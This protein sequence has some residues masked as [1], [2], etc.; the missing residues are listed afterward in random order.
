MSSST[1]DVNQEFISRIGDYGLKP[2]WDRYMTLMSLQPRVVSVPHRWR[3]Q[4]IKEFL[5]E[6]ADLVTAED[7]ERR[8]LLLENPALPGTC[9]VTETLLTGVQIISPGESAPLHRHVPSDARLILEGVE[10]A[11]TTVNGTK[12]E[13]HYADFIITPNWTWHD[14][15]HNGDTPVVWQD[16]LDIP[17][18]NSV[19]PVFFENAPQEEQIEE[20]LQDKQMPAHDATHENEK[21]GTDMFSP[22][23]RYPFTEAR[24]AMQNLTGEVEADPYIGYKKE[25]LN[26]DTGKSAMPTISVCLQYLPKSFKTLPYQTTEGSIF[27]CVEG[28]GTITVG[29]GDIAK[30][31]EF[32]KRDIFVV[33]CWYPYVLETSDD[34]YLFVSSDKAAQSKLGFWRENRL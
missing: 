25:Y 23:Q 14:H 6:A 30:T 10:G 28:E 24:E 17:L 15:G 22:I 21:T 20:N 26:P 7:A 33:P 32:S 12:L 31:F 11:F 19:G 2:L 34:T 27:T 5:V 8:V 13:M 18:V 29:E 1:T 4:K 16:V 3:Y 9:Q